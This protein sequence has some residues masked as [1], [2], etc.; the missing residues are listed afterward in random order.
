MLKQV[1]FLWISHLLII[2][3][4]PV[5]PE[6]PGLPARCVKTED[7]TWLKSYV[8]CCQCISDKRMEGIYTPPKS[9]ATYLLES[10]ALWR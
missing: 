7:T 1:L 8:K 3:S 4:P 5:L 6:A 2:D 10:V 9:S